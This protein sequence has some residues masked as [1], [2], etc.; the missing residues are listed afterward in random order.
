MNAAQIIQTK[1]NQ[2]NVSIASLC[3]TAGMSRSWFEKLKQRG[4]R[5][6][7]AFLIIMNHLDKIERGEE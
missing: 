7:E 3:R 6:L 4:N 2:N 1:A 5:S